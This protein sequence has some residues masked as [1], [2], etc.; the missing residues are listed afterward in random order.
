MSTTPEGVLK[1]SAISYLKRLIGQAIN[2]GATMSTA[3]KS[4]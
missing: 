1:Q 4:Q 3:N 2:E